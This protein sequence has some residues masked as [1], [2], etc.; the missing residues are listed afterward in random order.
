MNDTHNANFLKASIFITGAV[1]AY[2]SGT[3]TY[4]FMSD[5]SPTLG[6]IGILFEFIKFFLPM[7]VLYAFKADKRMRGYVLSS[8]GLLL[9]AMSFTASFIAVDT[10]FDKNRKE[11][12]EFL[13]IN[14]RI[15]MLSTQAK[16]VT[17]Q[18]AGLPVN[19]ITKRERLNDKAASIE[20]DIASL[21]DTRASLTTDSI[22]DQFGKQIAV[23]AAV[24]IEL[25]T[26]ATTIAL[27]LLSTNKETAAPV[28]PVV[29]Q[30]KKLKETKMKKLLIGAGLLAATSSPAM[31]VNA[32]RFNLAVC[33]DASFV[34]GYNSYNAMK[35]VWT[36]KYDH[37]PTFEMDAYEFQGRGFR[38][39]QMMTTG[40]SRDQV[41]KENYADR[42]CARFL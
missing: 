20:N 14:Q 26:I 36:N 29:K 9:I 19:Y 41:R 25:L 31:A 3:L 2:Y 24:I 17:E 13:A 38:K 4:Q 15:E 18:A 33:V 6:K 37:L 7:I 39:Q 16:R 10:G 34:H 21:I 22:A 30:T 23:A 28:K 12:A 40:K 8:I 42:N 35:T 11:S 1:V 27:S 5:L 32:E